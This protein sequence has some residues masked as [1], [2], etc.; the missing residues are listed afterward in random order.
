MMSNYTSD[1]RSCRVDFWKESGKWYTTEAVI[2]SDS[3]FNSKDIH[4]SFKKALK[5]HFNGNVRME[6]MRAT[7]LEPYHAYSHP[8]SLIVRDL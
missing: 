3:E 1:E 8:I 5:E 4:G 6:D 7:C 2:F